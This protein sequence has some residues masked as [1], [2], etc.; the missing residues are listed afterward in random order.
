MH[1]HEEVVG[2]EE[3]VLVYQKRLQGKLDD[4]AEE[5]QKPFSLLNQKHLNFLCV[6]LLHH[7]DFSYT[8]S[9]QNIHL[10]AHDEL[11]NQYS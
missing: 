1:V 6:L 11:G 4:T 8:L 3:V 10:L 5:L 7:K 9:F 2:V